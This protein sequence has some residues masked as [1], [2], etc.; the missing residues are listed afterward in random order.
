M[1]KKNKTSGLIAMSIVVIIYGVSYISREAVGAYLSTTAILAIQ[2]GIMALLFTLYNLAFRKSFKLRK[3]D[4][5]WI[6]L[7][8]LFGTTFFHGFTILS[9][10]SIGA[11]VSSLLYGFAA[12]FALIIEILLFKRK[13]TPMGIISILISFI[14][15]YILMDMNLNDLADTNFMGY[16]LCLGSVVSWVIY[17]FL[18]DKIS[19]DYEKSVLLNYQALVGLATTLPFMLAGSVEPE[20]FT[21]P[22]VIGNLLI[23]G[24]FN[25]TI[26]Y[27]LNM[28]AI[29]Q[30]GV[31]LSNL[32]LDFLPI[33][34]I[35]VS[36]LLYH[37]VPTGKQI[38]GG[39]LILISV[40]LLDKDQK[41]IEKAGNS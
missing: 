34:T 9:V 10:N 2:M 18:C 3:K 28:Y 30:I 33:V 19:S 5:P 38:T 25:S 23:L 11:T 17:T 13:K 32:F 12:A 35:L 26:A 40:F 24:L 36:L 1:N 16:L 31:T 20:M 7:S 4:I 21:K 15:I 22:A 14:G 29:K 41:N 37:T 39:I 27:F 8:G 6:I